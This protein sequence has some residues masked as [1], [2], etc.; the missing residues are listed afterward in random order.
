MRIQVWRD[1][2][3]SLAQP[4]PQSMS[5][6]IRP[7]GQGFMLWSWKPPRMETAEPFWV[8]ASHLRVATVVKL[9][10]LIYSQNLSCFNLCPFYFIPP[11]SHGVSSLT[12]L[13]NNLIA[14]TGTLLFGLPTAFSAPGWAEFD[15]QLCCLCYRMCQIFTWPTLFSLPAYL[16]IY[17]A[18]A[19][20]GRCSM[21][22]RKENNSV[23]GVHMECHFGIL[24][25]DHLH[26]SVAQFSLIP[27]MVVLSLTVLL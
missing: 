6:E 5:Y 23:L 21:R 17:T 4:A 11:L 26:C 2:R 9:F 19:Q 20:Q 15:L 27:S 7:A 24:F 12:D 25:L 1:L 10:W 22:S 16:T 14:V 8:M 18:H 3:R 13:S